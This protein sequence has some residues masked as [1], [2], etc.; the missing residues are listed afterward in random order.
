MDAKMLIKTKNGYGFGS[1]ES[2]PGA[3]VLGRKITQKEAAVALYKLG[4]LTQ[5][6]AADQMHCSKSN[7]NQLWQSLFFKLGTNSALTTVLKLIDLGVIKHLVLCLIIFSTG[8]SGISS[9]DVMRPPRPSSA[10]TRTRRQESDLR[11]VA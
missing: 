10:R 7:V 11:A 6:E 1:Y 3:V 8:I 9:T 4:E 2:I 5:A